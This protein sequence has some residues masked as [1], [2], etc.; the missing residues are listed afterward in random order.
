MPGQMGQ[1]FSFTHISA[2]TTTTIINGVGPSTGTAGILHMV[3]V[4]NPGTSWVVTLYDNTTNSGTVVGVISPTASTPPL[5]YDA[6]LKVGL[7]V[8]ATG[9]AGDLTILWA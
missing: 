1:G 6:Q 8:A 5:M 4:N 9:T 7:T 3:T 2:N